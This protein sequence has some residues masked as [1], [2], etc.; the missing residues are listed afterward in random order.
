M[1]TT[2]L[3]VASTIAILLLLAIRRKLNRECR[4]GEKRQLPINRNALRLEMPGLRAWWFILTRRYRVSP[5]LN[6]SPVIWV[7]KNNG[8]ATHLLLCFKYNYSTNKGGSGMH[9]TY[10]IPLDHVNVQRTSTWPHVQQPASG[11]PIVIAA[12]ELLTEPL[13]E[14]QAA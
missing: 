10:L 7:V 6:G 3:I 8:V 9:H 4:V 12:N 11:G 1:N 14:L 13:L 5:L 2:H